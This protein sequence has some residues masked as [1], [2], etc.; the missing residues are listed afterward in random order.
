MFENKSNIKILQKEEESVITFF[1][2]IKYE[3]IFL[4]FS[5]LVRHFYLKIFFQRLKNFCE[6]L[7]LNLF[8]N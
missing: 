7:M 8:F 6:F 4:Q 5:I 3:T 2:L 1:N